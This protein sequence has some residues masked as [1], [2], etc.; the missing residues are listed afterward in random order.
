M[1]P[2]SAIKNFVRRQMITLATQLDARSD[3]RI[4]PNHITWLSLIAHIPIAWLIVH[5]HLALA[6]GLL[7]VFGLL[8]S[9]DG[10]LARVQRSESARGMFLDSATDRMKETLIYIGVMLL[11]L[12]QNA[13]QL[14]IVATVVALAASLITSYLNAWGEVALTQASS[15]SPRTTKSAKLNQRLRVG[16]GFEFRVT[17]IVIGLL[18]NQLEPAIYAIALLASLTVIQRFTTILRKLA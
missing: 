12:D 13:S 1:G 16:L 5:N 11:L 6:G 3:S 17:I 4:T 2:V 14:T 8:D 10:A 7:I 18:A 9:L 15:S